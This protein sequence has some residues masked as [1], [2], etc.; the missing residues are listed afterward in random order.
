MQTSENRLMTKGNI[1]KEIVIFSI[2]LLVGNLFQQMYN[3]IDSVIVGNYVGV[4]ALAAV[5]S[6]APL[7]NMMIGLFMGFS[8]GA[9]VIISQYFGAGD[10]KNLKKSTNTCVAVSFIGGVILTITG[11]I[12]SKVMLGL[13]GTPVEVQEAA[14]TYLK[15][16][17][18][19]GISIV[20]Y[21]VVSGIMRA[22][23]DSKTPLYFL[24]VASV[25]N[26]ILD[27]IFVKV[28]GFGIKGAGYA[29]LISQTI[30]AILVLITLLRQSD[31]YRVRLKSLKIDISILKKIIKVGIPAG[32]QQSVISF[33]NV[34]VQSYINLFGTDAVAGCGAY[35]KIDGFVILPVLSFGMASTIFIGQNYGAKKM[36]RVKKGAIISSL[37]SVGYS[38][39]AS[40]I[41]LFFSRQVVSI[42]SSDE[43][44]ICYAVKMLFYF[45]PFYIFSS[46][47]Q[48]CCGVLR[49]FSVSTPPMII[50]VSNL[51]AVRLIWLFTMK[52]LNIIN[53]IDYVCVGYP[54]TWATAF[55]CFMIYMKRHK[56]FSKETYA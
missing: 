26:I 45:A 33:S 54:L 3:I 9:G 44:V 8:T 43:N 29:T 30:S 16:Y 23:G 31:L 7:I 49:G 50:M 41:L 20:V 56:Y 39:A 14:N 4:D 18:M 1:L 55:L 35:I 25:I 28:L 42:F 13:I 36:D 40:V 12:L 46:G 21:N 6:S 27:I 32:L 51:C 34:L 5:G 10:E 22:V 11:I 52:H 47:I 17:F 37:L 53:T 38:I 19:G 15:I 24:C 48:S 2:P